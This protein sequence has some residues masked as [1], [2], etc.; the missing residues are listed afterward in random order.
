MEACICGTVPGGAEGEREN[1]G[2]AAGTRG[3]AGGAGFWPLERFKNIL[4]VCCRRTSRLNTIWWSSRICPFR[5][6]VLGVADVCVV[7]GTPVVLAAGRGMSW[8]FSSILSAALD[9][10]DL[11]LEASE[12]LRDIGRFGGLRG[13]SVGFALLEG[14]EERP[15]KFLPVGPSDCGDVISGNKTCPEDEKLCTR[16]RAKCGVISGVLGA[17]G[18]SGN[19]IGH[20]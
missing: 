11:C 6:D 15:L 8:S 10:R 13:V 16:A 2:R 4:L 14:P 18:S 12:F 3:D 17:S 20:R 1:L 7:L 5:G 19:S 9:L